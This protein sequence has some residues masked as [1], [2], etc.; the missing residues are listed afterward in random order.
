MRFE[1]AK[2]RALAAEY[3]PPPHGELDFEAVPVLNPTAFA[4][5]L[6]HRVDKDFASPAALAEPHLAV[7]YRKPEGARTSCYVLN[8]I[9]GRLFSAWSGGE[10]S[11]ADG[12]RLVLAQLGRQPDARFIDGMA[13][14]LADLVEQKIILG[15]R[16]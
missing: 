9:G 10:R 5:P 2:W 3:D 14:V 13:G 15:S 4:V 16:R 1:D 11:C 6:R 12:A 8:D 7:V